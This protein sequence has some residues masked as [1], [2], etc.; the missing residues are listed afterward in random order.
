MYFSFVMMNQF[1]SP[2]LWMPLLQNVLD[3]FRIALVPSIEST[4]PSFWTKRFIWS[5]I[6]TMF[7]IKFIK[8]FH[9]N[10][11]T[12]LWD[13]RRSQTLPKIQGLQSKLKIKYETERKYQ[14]EKLLWK[15]MSALSNIINYAHLTLLLFYFNMN[16]S[17]ILLLTALIWM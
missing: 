6:Q 5:F 13:C 9:S 2:F 12:F 8:L 4:N 7:F 1:I 16:E 11:K 10:R 15:E 14:Q 3:W 17:F